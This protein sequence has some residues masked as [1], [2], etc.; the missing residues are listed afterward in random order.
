MSVNRGKAFEDV[1]KGAF[2]SVPNTHVKRLYDVQGGYLGVANEC[3]FYVFRSPNLYLIECKS[4]H[5]NLLSINSNDP[6]RKYGDIS[7]TQWE[8]ML[9]A[10]KKKNVVAGVMCWWVDKDVTKFLPIQL[11]HLEKFKGA[12]SIRY[13]YEPF[14]AVIEPS[15]NFIPIEGKKKRIFFDYDMESFFRLFE[16]GC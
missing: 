15:F 6:K 7:N 5:G 9:E 3:D 16:N 11:L 13:D 4:V 2:E 14:Q 1:V 8:G 10:S 12:K